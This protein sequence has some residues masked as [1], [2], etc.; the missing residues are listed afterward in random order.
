MACYRIQRRKGK[1]CTR[2]E[3]V[4]IILKKPQTASSLAAFFLGQNATMAT[5][6]K[7]LKVSVTLTLLDRE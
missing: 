7:K 3:T 6:T 1:R 5:M 2:V 4:T